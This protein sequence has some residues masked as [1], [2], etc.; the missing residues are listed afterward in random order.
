MPV[1]SGGPISLEKRAALA[2]RQYWHEL[3]E[4][5]IAANDQR[6]GTSRLKMCCT[7]DASPRLHGLPAAELTSTSRRSPQP[8]QTKQR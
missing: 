7:P 2:R 4:N 1:D 3:Y 5:A 6:T 8:R